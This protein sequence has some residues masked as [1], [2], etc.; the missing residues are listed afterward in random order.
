[1]LAVFHVIL[2]L[3][4]RRFYNTHSVGNRRDYSE[5]SSCQE[6]EPKRFLEL[7]EEVTLD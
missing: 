5:V 4:Q 6:K 1:M 2:L 7:P 3:K